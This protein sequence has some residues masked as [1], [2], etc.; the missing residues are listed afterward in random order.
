MQC[1]GVP[2]YSGSEGG[3][4]SLP[5]PF[6]SPPPPPPP[7]SAH[8]L[9]PKGGIARQFA[10]YRSQGGPNDLDRSLRFWAN[11][12]SPQICVPRHCRSSPLVSCP[13][14]SAFQTAIA[15]WPL[16]G[17]CRRKQRNGKAGRKKGSSTRSFPTTMPA[18]LDSSRPIMSPSVRDHNRL[19]FSHDIN[20]LATTIRASPSPKN[21]SSL[22]STEE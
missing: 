15:P 4:S 17:S 21:L 3:A 19:G 6:S 12:P 8:L 22:N 5:S 11:R 1:R 2:V 10:P 20:P 18:S 14:C 9:H 16:P 7:S 13:V